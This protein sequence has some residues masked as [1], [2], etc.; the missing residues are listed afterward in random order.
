MPLTIAIDGPVGAGKSTISDQVAKALDILHLD[1]GAMYRAVGY[2]ALLRGAD[3]LDEEAVAALLPDL[4]MAV[5]YQ[6]GA[7]R[8]LLSGQDVTELIRTPKISMAASNVGKWPKVRH[9]MV[10]LQRQWA[11]GQSMLLD[12]RDIGTVVL[13]DATVKIFLTASPEERARRR[14]LELVSKGGTDSYEKVLAE[15]QLRDAQDM[16]REIDPLRPADDAVIVDTTHLSFDESV[17]KILLI[18][19]AAR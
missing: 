5:K 14:H 19:E 15:L 17:Q 13:P 11:A 8:T 18:V 3:P 1:T 4:Q 9:A 7:Q 12:G 2:Y 10:Q 6:D 16:N